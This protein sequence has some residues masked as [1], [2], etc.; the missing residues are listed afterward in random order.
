MALI[1]EL[2]LYGEQ[3]VMDTELLKRITIAPG[4]VGGKPTIRR[5]G[6][7]VSDVPGYF[8]AGMNEE[9]LLNDFPCLE[10][11]DITACLL[12]A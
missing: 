12:Y 10:K 9:D 8:L 2:Y 4:L 1:Q 7:K 5:I 11:G 3:I 6:L